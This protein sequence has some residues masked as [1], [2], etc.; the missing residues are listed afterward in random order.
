MI[1]QLMQRL[2]V[3]INMNNAAGKNIG[4]SDV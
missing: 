2:D 1:G 3:K 4:H